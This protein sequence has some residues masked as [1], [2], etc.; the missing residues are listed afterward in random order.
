[1]KL[2]CSALLLLA[3]AMAP[4]LWADDTPFEVQSGPY[5][6]YYSLFPSTFLRPEVAAAYG[7]VR[8]KNR[9]VLNVSILERVAEGDR[10]TTRGKSALVRGTRS[11]L[12]HKTPLEFAEVR[13]QDAVYYL[14]E[15]PFGG[16]S[17][18]LYFE[19]RVEPDP[20]ASPIDISFSKQL[21]AE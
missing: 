1:M 20:D 13:E 9:A 6:V 21:S 10:E 7:I 8:G 4:A 3:A 15:V 18:R 2:I 14:A 19:L 17:P 11:D 12:I 16:T 5:T